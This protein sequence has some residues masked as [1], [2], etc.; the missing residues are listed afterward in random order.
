MTKLLVNMD[1][2]TNYHFENK[3]LFDNDDKMLQRCIFSKHFE[4]VLL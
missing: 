3:V 2:V 1:S 4:T